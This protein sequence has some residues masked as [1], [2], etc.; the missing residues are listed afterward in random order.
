MHTV[1][2]DVPEQSV[3]RAAR[4]FPPILKVKIT[5]IRLNV[6]KPVEKIRLIDPPQF[7]DFHLPHHAGGFVGERC[8]GRNLGQRTG[9]GH[10][11]QFLTQSGRMRG[12][13][14]LGHPVEEINRLEVLAVP[15][16]A[17]ETALGGLVPRLGVAIRMMVRVRADHAG[18]A[19]RIR[20]L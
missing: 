2:S 9:H 16:I 11:Q 20:A 15:V 7:F 1:A 6:S 8:R 17:A 10:G 5:V 19:L 12:A 14:L 18:P 13:S 3:E 4:Q